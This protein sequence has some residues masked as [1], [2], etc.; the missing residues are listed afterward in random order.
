MVFIK[1]TP[2]IKRIKIKIWKKR[3]KIRRWKK[4]ILCKQEPKIASVTT[5]ITDKIDLM[6]KALLEI[7]ENIS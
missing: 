2:Q 6:Q 5:V 4:D 1:D 7:K 3:I